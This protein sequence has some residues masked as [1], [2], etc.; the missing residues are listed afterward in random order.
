ME[1]DTSEE[2]F[3]TLRGEPPGRERVFLVARF[4]HERPPI[5]YGVDGVDR[6]PKE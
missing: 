2:G 4:L 6:A 3:G 5:V 1:S